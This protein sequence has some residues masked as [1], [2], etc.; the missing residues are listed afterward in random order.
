MNVLCNYGRPLVLLAAVALAMPSQL[1]ARAVTGGDIEEC[2]TVHNPSQEC[3]S[4]M[5]CGETWR[6][7][8][9]CYSEG[10]GLPTLD[11]ENKCITHPGGEVCQGAGCGGPRTQHAL[12]SNCITQECN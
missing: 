10:P 3:N 9:G 7:C 5:P 11:K 4:S 6:K 8:H 1:A 2:N 12:D